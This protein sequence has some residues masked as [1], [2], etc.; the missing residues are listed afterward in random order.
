[1]F[2]LSNRNLG[3]ESSDAEHANHAKESSDVA[4]YSQGRDDLCPQSQSRSQSLIFAL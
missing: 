2:N 3:L 1:V 4:S